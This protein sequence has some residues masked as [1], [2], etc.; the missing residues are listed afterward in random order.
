[1][2]QD[3]GYSSTEGS[4]YNMRKAAQGH[5]ENFAG[6]SRSITDT[7][8]SK[9]QRQDSIDRLSQDTAEIEH[10]ATLPRKGKAKPKPPVKREAEVY[11]AYLHRQR[12]CD[13]ALTENA[14]HGLETARQR[15]RDEIRQMLVKDY[16]QRRPKEEDVPDGPRGVVRTNS[17]LSN[18]SYEEMIQRQVQSMALKERSQPH[19]G[20]VRV[21]PQ[22]STYPTHPAGKHAHAM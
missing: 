16:Y 13:D 18:L 20:P 21:L 17:N 6:I 2:K 15:S 7:Q 10:F 5:Q 8:I 1:M 14:K 22:T 19:S 9:R 3:S 4:H 11:Q 12:S